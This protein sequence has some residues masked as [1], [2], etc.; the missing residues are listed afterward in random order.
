MMK[1]I[2]FGLFAGMLLAGSLPVLAD[3]GDRQWHSDG[4][5]EGREIH[6]FDH[7]DRYI[8]QTGRWQHGYHGGRLGWWWIAAGAW[9]FYPQPV[10]PYPD[11]YTPPVTVIS[12]QPAPVVAQPAQVQPQQTAQLYYYCDSAKGY[13]PYVSSCAEGWQSVQAQPPQAAP[14]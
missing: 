9:Y 11:P 14:H 2:A 5:W 12:Q 4:H 3:H 1:Q 13:Y 10:Y 7:R 6:R 8:W